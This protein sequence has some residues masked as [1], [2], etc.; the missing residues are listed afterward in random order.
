[1]SAHPDDALAALA[2]RSAERLTPA[3]VPPPPS[4]VDGLPSIHSILND[5][6]AEAAAL[7]QLQARSRKAAQ[8]NSRQTRLRLAMGGALA[9]GLVAGIYSVAQFY[10]NFRDRDPA[11]PPR[12]TLVAAPTAAV[13][14]APPSPIEGGVTPANVPTPGNSDVAAALSPRPVATAPVQIEPGAAIGRPTLSEE[15]LRAHEA[16]GLPPPRLVKTVRIEPPRE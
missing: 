7:A 13:P 11:S 6:T 1:M 2:R 16:L 12:A 15:W 10:R 5:P 3:L 9:L 14:A 4:G 8:A